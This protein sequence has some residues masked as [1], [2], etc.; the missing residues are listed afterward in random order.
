MY[1]SQVGLV[2]AASDDLVQARK[3]TSAVRL[4]MQRAKAQALSGFVERP[5]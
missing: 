1:R 3:H 5:V 2:H 4:C